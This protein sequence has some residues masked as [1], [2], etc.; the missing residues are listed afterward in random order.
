VTVSVLSLPLAKPVPAPVFTELS[1]AAIV[2]T[3]QVPAVVHC[4]DAG[5]GTVKVG[6]VPRVHRYRIGAAPVAGPARLGSMVAP[7]FA[8]VTTGDCPLLNV[9]TPRTCALT[10][11][12]SK[13]TG[14]ASCVNIADAAAASSK[15]LRLCIFMLY[16]VGHVEK[17]HKGIC[18]YPN[19][20]SEPTRTLYPRPY[21]LESD[22]QG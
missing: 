3:P 11:E 2:V 7:L 13:S 6:A 9:Q 20:T 17:T 18:V 15:V 19:Q 14:A 10:V 16:R 21:P 8:I 12:L 4:T 22:A 5:V 1:V